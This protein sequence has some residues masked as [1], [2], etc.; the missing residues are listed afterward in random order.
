MIKVSVVGTD[1]LLASLQKAEKKLQDGVNREMDA[2]VMEINAKQIAAAPVDKGILRAGNR[3][4]ITRPLNKVLYNKI[5]YAPYQE[6]GTGGLVNIPQGLE[7]EA[8]IFRGA[9]IREVNMRAQPF[10]F[11]P[12]FEEIPKLL[13]AVENILK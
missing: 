9:G 5:E 4:D 2:A 7:A 11:R 6:F 13:K 10:F 8:E 1:K 12:Y 3:Y